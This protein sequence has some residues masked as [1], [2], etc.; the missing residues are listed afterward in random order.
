MSIFDRRHQSSISSSSAW[1][2]LGFPRN[3]F[4]LREI[5]ALD[6]NTC[7]VKYYEATEKMY[8]IKIEL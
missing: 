3:S 2:D 1:F 6:V 4:S 7:T 8:I 5:C